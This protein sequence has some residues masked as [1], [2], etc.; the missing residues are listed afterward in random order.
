MDEQRRQRLAEIMAGLAGGDG[1]AVHE[2]YEEFHRE[3][4][5]VARALAAS[6]GVPVLDADE[7]DGL[8]VE[9]VLELAEVAGT[10]D[11][12][13]GALPWRWAARRLASTV[14]RVIGQHHRPLDEVGLASLASAS[15]VVGAADEP[16]LATLARLADRD[17][18]CAQLLDA[19]SAALSDRDADVW[20]RYRQQ[21]LQ[22]D[23]SPARTVGREVGLRPDAVRQ[24]AARGRRRLR[25]VVDA[26]GRYAALGGLA[27]LDTDPRPAA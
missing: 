13:G 2:L 12:D 9:I 10:W 4:A 21:Q 23:P 17:E 19:V 18:R 5:G 25:A 20:L 26:D 1:V 16:P 14:A 27:L 22:G 6:Q 15:P 7:L 11:A 3:L 8:V 24:I